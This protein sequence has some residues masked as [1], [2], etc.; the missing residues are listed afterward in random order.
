MAD[1]ATPIVHLYI[2][3]DRSGS[4]QSMVGSVL[5]GF[6]GLLDKQL[7]DGPDARVTLVQFD[8]HDPHEVIADGV[9]IAEMVPL[10]VQVFEPRGGTPLLDATGRMIGRAAAHRAGLL[11]QGHPAEQIVMVT[12]TDGEENQSHEFNRQQLVELVTAKTAEGWSFVYLGAGIDAYS[13]AEAL[14]YVP[15]SVQAW[16]P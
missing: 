4:M 5:E 6:N 8:S 10:T 16:A 15:R 13:D 12:I 7:A 11:E 9:P 1:D 14:G 3:L 2:L